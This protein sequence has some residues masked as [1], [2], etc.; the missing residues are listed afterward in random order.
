MLHAVLDDGIAGGGGGRVGATH[1]RYPTQGGVCPPTAAPQGFHGSAQPAG[2]HG[3]SATELRDTHTGRA[4][5]HPVRPRNV[6]VQRPGPHAGPRAGQREGGRVYHPDGR[7]GGFCALGGGGGGGPLRSPAAGG[8][9]GAAARPA[10]VAP[11]RGGQEAQ[12]ARHSGGTCG[13]ECRGACQEEAFALSGY[14]RPQAQ[15]QLRTREV[16]LR[17]FPFHPPFRRLPQALRLPP[18]RPVRAVR[19]AGFIHHPLFRLCAVVEVKWVASSSLLRPSH[20][21]AH[22]V[23]LAYGSR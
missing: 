14:D 22:T 21:A 3:D 20:R 2:R 9:A 16:G 8:G 23:L 12:G 1:E 18:P 13:G 19:P 5:L 17:G 7:C 11:G 10:P 15:G 4:D 6:R